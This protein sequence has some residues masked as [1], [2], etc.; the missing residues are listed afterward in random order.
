M[1]ILLIRKGEKM[2]KPYELLEGV[3]NEI[4][5][6]LKK[7]INDTVLADKFSLS[8]GHLRR[9]FKFAFGQS[10]GKYIRSRKLAASI[11]DLL[12]TDIN[13]LDIVLDYGLDYK[14]SYNRTFKR[15]FG[16]TPGE[17]RKS[18]QVVKITPP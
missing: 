7:D 17:L 13:I 18:R 4:E 12:L 2:L 5:S 11:E 15:E 8:P 10:L 14:Q 16:I 6:G 3:L 9:L 1:S